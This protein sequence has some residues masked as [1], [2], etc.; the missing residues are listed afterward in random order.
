LLVD[1]SQSM[2]FGSVAHTKV[3]YARTLAATFA[4]FLASQRDAVG[5]LTFHQQIVDYIP[6]RF[7]PGHLHRLFVSLE[8]ALA[9]H[10]TDLT[11][12]MEHIAELVSRRGLIVLISD[13]L[14]PIEQLQEKL[15]YLR[16]RGHEVVVM[17]ILD[18]AERD[19]TFAGASMFE[20]L[21]SGRR[22]YVDPDEVRQQYLHNFAEHARQLEEICGSLGVDL[23]EFTTQR[24]LEMALFDFMQARQR[25][26]RSVARRHAMSG[27]SAG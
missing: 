7:R 1:L 8:G 6:A 19:F 21:E 17:R 13:L 24:P 3:D 25:R 14:A 26:G 16:S 12:P 15:G 20:D 2:G 23:F 18:P 9:G 4:Y 11:R 22:M 27:A 10:A 5:L